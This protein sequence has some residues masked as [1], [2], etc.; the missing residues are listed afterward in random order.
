MGGI[1]VQLLDPGLADP[2]Q[3][4][5]DLSLRITAGKRG[6]V[7]GFEHSND[8]AAFLAPA[9]GIGPVPLEVRGMARHLLLLQLGIAPGQD[10]KDQ[11]FGKSPQDGI[12][13]GIPALLHIITGQGTVEIPA[14]IVQPA[15]MDDP[16]EGGTHRGVV[17]IPDQDVPNPSFHGQRQDAEQEY[18]YRPQADW[19]NIRPELCIILPDKGHEPDHP[20][21][22]PVAVAPDPG[23]I[24]I[25]CRQILPGIDRGKPVPSGFVYEYGMRLPVQFLQK[26]VG[27]QAVLAP[28]AQDQVTVPSRIPVLPAV[29]IAGI[30]GVGK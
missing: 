7:K 17:F 2:L 8:P 12:L 21:E 28:A 27:Q 9:A 18:R 10:F 6:G 30:A 16:P 15:V 23:R 29:G 22:D 5:F 11:E 24:G 3:G 26:A 13:A 14:L 19:I 25:R 4:M 1:G 20:A